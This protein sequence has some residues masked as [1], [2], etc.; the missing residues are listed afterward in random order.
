MTTVAFNVYRQNAEFVELAHEFARGVAIIGE[1]EEAARHGQELVL[2]GGQIDVL[3]HAEDVRMSLAQMAVRDI[4]R[5]EARGGL[6]DMQLEV[7][8]E[9][10]HAHHILN[11]ECERAKE[12][13]K[14]TARKAAMQQIATAIATR[15]GGPDTI[16][17]MLGEVVE[18]RL[19]P[20]RQEAETA[21]VKELT[22]I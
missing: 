2:R 4:R 18:G 12:A 17:E 19:F 1:I 11:D 10:L 21:V 13:F 15:G 5:W 8:D 22:S 7:L 6:L 3:T 9:V 14:G 16:C 20:S